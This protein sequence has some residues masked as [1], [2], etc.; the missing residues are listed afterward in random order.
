MRL[1]RRGR[2]LGHHQLGDQIRI[3]GT[4]IQYNLKG[5]ILSCGSAIVALFQ[6]CHIHL[7]AFNALPRFANVLFPRHQGICQRIVILAQLATTAGK[8]LIELGVIIIDH[9]LHRKVWAD[10]AH[11]V[12][13]RL[14]PFGRTAVSVPIVIHRD[15]LLFE[16]FV[17]NGGIQLIVI[18][19]RVCHRIVVR[20]LTDGP[21]TTLAIAFCP[22]SVQNRGIEASVHLRLHTAR[23][24]RFHR[25]DRRIEP[26][27]H[28][29]NQY[30]CK[31]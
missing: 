4:A 3:I 28:T 13:D 5:D 19:R 16:Q 20:M 1:A 18:G 27:I 11:R 14:N 23:S 17:Q 26:H 29:G 15:D 12:L 21:T 22:P 24:A 9:T 7:E 8:W 6:S 31:L 2:Y 10:G 30:F 25:P